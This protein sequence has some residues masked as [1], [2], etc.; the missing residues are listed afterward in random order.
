MWQ[1]IQTPDQL[2]AIGD[3]ETTI[4]DFKAKPYGP[5]KKGS[6]PAL[7]I[8]KDVAAFANARGGTLLIGACEKKGAN[9]LESFLSLTP[10][11][12]EQAS[13]DIDDAVK[14]RCFPPPLVAVE[15]IPHD[16]GFVV[17]VNVQPFPGQV[18]GVRLK[19]DES[20][21]RW[22]HPYAFPYR[23]GTQT[24][25][26]TPEQLP[27]FF[28][29]KARRVAIAL[30][31]VEGREVAFLDATGSHKTSAGRIDRVDLLTNAV[32]LRVKLDM[33]I[34]AMIPLDM[35]DSVCGDGDACFV[36]VRGHFKRNP[37]NRNLDQALRVPA[38]L[39]RVKVVLV[40]GSD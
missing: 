28:D 17:A 30:Q 37:A 13:R 26:L 21:P 38:A 34:D 10:E 4:L 14:A 25:Y 31:S 39:S 8:G 36:Y 7:E 5:S 40:Q 23:V 35:V 19:E 20:G 15:K 1:P 16:T 12:A 3:P 27:M 11:G 29:P 18:V 22:D 32:H 33:E 2:P 24:K 6:P 9:T